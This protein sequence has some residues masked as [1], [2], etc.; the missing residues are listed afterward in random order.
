MIRRGW[1]SID[2]SNE[3]A[4]TGQRSRYAVE[5]NR[6]SLAGS[7]RESI[8]F[9]FG[10]C[11]LSLR[12]DSIIFPELNIL[13]QKVSRRFWPHRSNLASYDEDYTFGIA[14]RTQLYPALTTLSPCLYRHQQSRAYLDCFSAECGRCTLAAGRSPIH[15][16][17]VPVLPPV[18]VEP[19]LECRKQQMGSLLLGKVAHLRQM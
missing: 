16:R 1:S 5:H 4:E 10:F 8:S 19:V 2:R 15:L 11:A 12:R 7:V 14:I 9:D 18:Q 6:A 3:G 13:S 17:E